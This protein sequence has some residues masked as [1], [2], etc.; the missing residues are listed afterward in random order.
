[1]IRIL[2]FSLPV[3]F[4]FLIV[5]CTQEK[6]YIQYSFSNDS[7]HQV[8][9]IFYNSGNKVDEIDISQTDSWLSGQIDERTGRHP[10]IYFDT[11]S[12][13]VKFN[14]KKQLIFYLPLS[15]P[16]SGFEFNILETSNYVRSVKDDVTCLLYTFTNE[17]Y[18]NAEEIV[19]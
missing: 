17:H 19:D 7:D 18:N 8:E 11:D 9:I 10:V 1:M 2:F 13:S 6:E 12:V 3:T 14:D 5:S 16:Q 4:L 15:A